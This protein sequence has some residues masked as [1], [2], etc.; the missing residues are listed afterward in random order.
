MSEEQKPN[1]LKKHL[2]TVKLRAKEEEMK[3]SETEELNA[4]E[5]CRL[6][7]SMNNYISGAS[8]LAQMDAVINKPLIH[9]L[10]KI[11]TLN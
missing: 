4:D 10:G 1:F 8:F 5:I 2:L 6:I 7:A 11:K 3:L 9:T